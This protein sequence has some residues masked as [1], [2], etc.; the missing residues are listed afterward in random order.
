M[1]SVK[2]VY[3]AAHHGVHDIF[4][5]ARAAQATVETLDAGQLIVLRDLPGSAQDD[6]QGMRWSQAMATEAS[7]PAH[8]L[9]R[10]LWRAQAQGASIAFFPP[11]G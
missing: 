3:I 6:L 11:L 1:D 9:V 8:P 5:A 4:R 2:T 7:L 10:A